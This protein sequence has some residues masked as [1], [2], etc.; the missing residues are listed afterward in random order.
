MYA[1]SFLL[2]VSS[3]FYNKKAC[4]VIATLLP[5]NVFLN[6]FDGRIW[7]ALLTDIL[8]AKCL[9]VSFLVS[10]FF[11]LLKQVRTVKVSNLP[12]AA[13]VSDIEN[14]ISVSGHI[15]YIEMRR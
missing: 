1:F 14:K 15:V 8:E 2:F 9:T 13:S 5:F 3:L 11:F 6:N 12:L 4:C 7:L 10:T